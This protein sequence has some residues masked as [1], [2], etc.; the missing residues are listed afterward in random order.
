MLCHA[1]GANT[2]SCHSQSVVLM[3]HLGRPNGQKSAKFSLAPAVKVL[4]QH[5][6]VPVKFL[7]DC[8]GPEVEAA[9]ADPAAGSVILLENLRFHAAE[10]GKGVDAD[11]NKVKATKEDVLAFRQSLSKLGDLY[12]TYTA[13]TS[14]SPTFADSHRFS[15]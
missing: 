11:G 13:T 1:S 6:S 14:S 8:V 5:L 3:S 10:E 12:G 4:E 2:Q 15:Q 7:E 9:C